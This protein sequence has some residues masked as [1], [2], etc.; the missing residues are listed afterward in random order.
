VSL[1]DGRSESVGESR[2]RLLLHRPG[3]APTAVQVVGIAADGSALGRADFGWEDDRV[4][5]EFDGHVKYRRLL[6]PGQDPGDVV[7]EEKR[8]EDAF[9]DAGWGVVRWT[10]ADLMPGT[11]VGDRVRRALTRARRRLG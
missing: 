5:G 7:F 11:V 3:L 9:R 4:V 1:A 2:S 6:R 10:W 8:R